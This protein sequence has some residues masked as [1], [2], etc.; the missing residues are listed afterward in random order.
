MNT[1]YLS[2]HLGKDP[3]IRA[4]KTGTDVISFSVATNEYMGKDR[5]S[6]TNWHRVVC[7]SNIKSESISHAKK[8]DR[9][10][11]EGRMDYSNS[12]DSVGKETWYTS[13]I[14]KTVMVVPK[15]AEPKSNIVTPT[16]GLQ[17]IPF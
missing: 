11:V 16:M 1:I 15:D 5:D 4:T 8:G 17:D 12:K 9:V 6:K 14:A 2:G 13:V 3:E 7:F 10:F